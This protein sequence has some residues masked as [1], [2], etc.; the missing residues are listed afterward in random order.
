M[1]IDGCIGESPSNCASRCACAAS[2]LPLLLAELDGAPLGGLALLG[3]QRALELV[4]RAGRA[5]R[6]GSATRPTSTREVLRDLVR[7]EVDVDDLRAGCEHALERGEDLGED[8]RAADQHGVGLRGD[9]LRVVAEHVT[10]L[11]AEERVVGVDV[12]PRSSSRPTPPRRAARRRASARPAR[13][14][15]R[16]RRRRSTIGRDAPASSAA[17]A[18][19]P[20]RSARRACR[21]R[22][23]AR[24]P[25]S[26][27]ASSTSIGSATNTGPHGGVAAILIAFRSTRSVEVG[28]T[29]RV[30]HLVTGRAIETRSAA[31]CASIES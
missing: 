16:C 25:R 5:S 18:R 30:D 9:R 13:P 22:S 26:I 24:P 28:S 12:R 11:A 14:R 27:S 21:E 20:R 31:I 4:G 15:T 2:S 23:S 3:R 29:T 8:V 19:S 17:A 6:F 10:E 1:K 7:V